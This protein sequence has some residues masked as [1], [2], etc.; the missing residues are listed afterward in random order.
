MVALGE[1]YTASAGIT[2]AAF[3]MGCWP[4][5]RLDEHWRLA[6]TL[7]YQEPADIVATVEQR[8]ADGQSLA[9]ACFGLPTHPRQVNQWAWM[10]NLVNGKI[11]RQAGEQ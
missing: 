7:P 3:E 8:M 6:K 5:S 2:D 1:S 10:R 9:D 11:D 4:Q